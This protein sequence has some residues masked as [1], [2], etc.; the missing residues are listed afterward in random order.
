VAA[1]PVLKSEPV[2]A[3]EVEREGDKDFWGEYYP[4]AHAHG[5]TAERPASPRGAG[6]GGGSPGT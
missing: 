2:E 1:R 5:Q 3:A 6:A 4:V